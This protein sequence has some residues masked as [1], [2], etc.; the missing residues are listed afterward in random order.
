MWCDLLIISLTLRTLTCPQF[1]YEIPIAVP[2]S[3][4]TVT[5][6][7]YNIKGFYLNPLAHWRGTPIN[8]GDRVICLS[9]GSC[10]HEYP[11]NPQSVGTVA[12]HGCFR[13]HSIDFLFEATHLNTVILIEE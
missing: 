12:T 8:V 2:K 10:I 6:G 4:Y 11:S 5:P 9:N 1:E 7:S 3:G 13:V